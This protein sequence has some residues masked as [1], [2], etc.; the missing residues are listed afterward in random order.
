M[1]S[2][3]NNKKLVI[4]LSGLIIVLILTM[5]VKI[6]KE[7][8]TL[9][10]RL[11]DIDTSRVSKIIITP[12]AETGKPFEFIRENNKWTVRQ[13]KV[14][15]QPM[16]NA[17][18]NI[19]SEILQLKPQSLVAVDKSKWKEY[20]LTDSLATK[21]KLLDRKGKTLGDQMV[22]KFTYRQAANPYGYGG[23]NNI[24]G[25]SF[26]RL[27]DDKKIYSVEGFLAFSFGGTFND[28]R[29]KSFLRCKKE[30]I[31]KITF[32]YPADSSFI[33]MKKDSLWYAG[34]QLADSLKTANYFSSL[35]F[36][37]GEE[38]MDGFRPSS[39]P[40]YSMTIEGNNLLNVTVKCFRE[41]GNDKYV[42]NS[43]LNPEIYFSGAKNGLFEK[44]FK[45]ASYF[46]KK[47]TAK[48]R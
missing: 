15:S 38:F 28:W 6:P 13:D 43:S 48:K 18:E 45:P 23:G 32:T 12:K 33:L 27:A 44:L 41:G 42:L 7:R 24:E 30:D 2:R 4:I 25:T 8:S 40:L 5:V 14:I 29:D 34:S 47:E 46:G 35:S 19:F 22:G 1:S 10:A 26:V 39:S 3:F 31:S 11:F 9:T 21:I 37:D 36:T 16:Q 17:V 20:E